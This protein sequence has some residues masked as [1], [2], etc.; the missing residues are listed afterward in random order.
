MSN[1]SKRTPLLTIREMRPDDAQAFLEVHHAAVRAIATKDYPPSVIEAWAP[2]P[3]TEDAVE[4]VR[5]NV[6]KEYRL[7]AEVDGKIVGIGAL[8]LEKAELRACYVAPEASRKGVGSALVREIE[9]I[10]CKRGLHYLILDSSVTAERFYASLGYEVRD[11]GEHILDSGRS[12]ACVKMHKEI[13]S[14]G[15]D[16]F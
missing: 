9:R 4:R 1:R 3:L 10:A 11:R 15:T 14:G 5:K 8:V 2:L 16:V 6:E 12:M 13:G 7:I